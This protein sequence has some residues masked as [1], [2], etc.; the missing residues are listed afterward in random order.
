MSISLMK[1]RLFFHNVSIINTLL[2]SLYEKLYAGC[3][4]LLTEA[5]EL[6]THTHPH[7]C[8]HAHMHTCTHTLCFTFLPTKWYPQTASFRGPKKME[9]RGCYI[10]TVDRIRA[11]HPTDQLPPLCTEWCAVWCCHAGGG[12]DSSSCLAEPF[13]FAALYL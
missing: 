2:P 6:F 10:R 9:I 13:I 8:M 1:F 5:W 4:K 12:L 7:T 3:V 11:V